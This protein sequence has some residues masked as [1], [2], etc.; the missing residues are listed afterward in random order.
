MKAEGQQKFSNAIGVLGC[1]WVFSQ[2]LL[3]FFFLGFNIISKG[4]SF[5]VSN[6]RSVAKEDL[7]FSFLK[8]L[9]IKSFSTVESRNKNWEKC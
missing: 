2:V 8:H 6:L 3:G 9:N 1:M 4:F 7:G 5:A